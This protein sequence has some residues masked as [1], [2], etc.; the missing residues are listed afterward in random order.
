MFKIVPYSHAPFLPQVVTD[1][2]VANLTEKFG[3]QMRTVDVEGCSMLTPRSLANISSK[4]SGLSSFLGSRCNF[5]REQPDFARE[6]SLAG[7]MAFSW[8]AGLTH[9]VLKDCEGLDDTAVQKIVSLSPKLET[10]TLAHTPLLSDRAL[11]RVGEHCPLLQRLN[12]QYCV[13]LTDYGFERV[14]EGCKELR[15]ILVSGC[16]LLTDA[17]LVSMK[18]N[19]PHLKTVVASKGGNPHLTTALI[20]ELNSRR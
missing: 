17:T 9:I 6:N 10:L 8:P 4:C 12:V 19:L 7:P 1:Q 11:R 2:L 13:K 16:E 5:A 14:M 18:Q 3:Q 20:D 15:A